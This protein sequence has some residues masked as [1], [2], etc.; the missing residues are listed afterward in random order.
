L[1]FTG[2]RE[3]CYRRRPFCP[4]LSA[5]AGTLSCRRGLTCRRLAG[6]ATLCG[7]DQQAQHGDSKERQH[8]LNFPTEHSASYSMLKD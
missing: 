4:A 1:H 7:D 2:H 3:S 5:C 6:S 8:N